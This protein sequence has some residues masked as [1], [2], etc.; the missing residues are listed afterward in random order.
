MNPVAW[1]VILCS[2][3]LMLFNFFYFRTDDEKNAGSNA[4][5]EI[6]YVKSQTLSRC[7][8]GEYTCFATDKGGVW[9]DPLIIKE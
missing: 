4:C 1:L 2:L 9:C 3:L 8:S 6:G 7:E 5:K